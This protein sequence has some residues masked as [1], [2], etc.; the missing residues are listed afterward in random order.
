MLGTRRRARHLFWG[1]F[2]VKNIL[3]LIGG[4]PRDQVIFDTALA[5]AMP[6]AARVNFLHIHVTAGEAAVGTRA[7]FARGPAVGVALRQL[8]ERARAY[9][10][11]AADHIRDLCENSVVPIND[12]LDVGRNSV[13]ASYSE[14]TD[15]ALKRLTENALRNDLVV[16]GR[17]KQTHG[18]P[19]RTLEHLIRHSSRPMLVAASGSPREL[20]GTA[21]VFWDGS[22]GATRAV[23]AAKPLL[24]KARRVV[25][26]R[27]LYR[28]KPD[29]TALTGIIR[30]L[31]DSDIKAE[32]L[33]ISSDK[34]DLAVRLAGA[35][36]E[37]EADLV[38]MGAYGRGM[39]RELLF[40]SRTEALLSSTDR[41]ILL[42]H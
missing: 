32:S 20:T 34:R 21:I 40:G 17:L 19:S 37:C 2:V 8:E 36:D 9:S 27:I 33:P 16:I 38:V 4:G 13:T 41:P 25:V 18:L 31:A 26:T 5:A 42:V 7:E 15:Q 24:T 14:E 6:F 39:V 23:E 35:A 30:T 29:E 12:T 10:R 3:A 28:R 22:D 1:R 11:A